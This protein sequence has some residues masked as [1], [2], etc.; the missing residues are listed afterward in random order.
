MHDQIPEEIS[1]SDSEDQNANETRTLQERERKISIP[2]IACIS[3]SQKTHQRAPYRKPW[4]KDSIPVLPN[5]HIS[6]CFPHT[7]LL[8]LRT[9][10][11]KQN[12]S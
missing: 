5:K 8:L 4:P 1:H 11:K 3:S 2:K 12:P 6:A 10:M 7:V 9:R